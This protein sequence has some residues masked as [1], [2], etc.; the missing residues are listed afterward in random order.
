MSAFDISV[1]EETIIDA[2]N[3]TSIVPV[4]EGEYEGIIEDYNFRKT[5]ETKRGERLPLDIYW[6]IHDEA[7]QKKLNRE[8]VTAKQGMLL[9]VNEDGSLA[10]GPGQNVDL[11]RL[12]AA[13][14]M[15]GKNFSFLKLKGAGPARILITHRQDEKTDDVYS[16]VRKVVPAS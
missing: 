3:A 8:T 16:E 14:G 7:L 4:P 6:R 1:L 11:G 10:V 9:E 15:N 2:A 12:R 5:I 13:L